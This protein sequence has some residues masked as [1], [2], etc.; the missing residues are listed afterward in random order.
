M[1]FLSSA[2][3]VDLQICSILIEIDLS[4]QQSLNM[5]IILLD[6]V[7]LLLV[8]C[9]TT[10]DLQTS[11]IGST[12]TGLGFAWYRNSVHKGILLRT[13]KLGLDLLLPGPH[14]AFYLFLFLGISFERREGGGNA[15]R[16]MWKNS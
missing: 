16:E 5:K 4:R 2:Q 8:Y 10:L 12:L 1:L 7:V 9:L 13:Q 14:V 11:L 3:R 6:S 15:C